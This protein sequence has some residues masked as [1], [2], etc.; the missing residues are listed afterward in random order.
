M[1]KV[2]RKGMNS[3]AHIR[4]TDYKSVR[5]TLPVDEVHQYVIVTD[6]PET[7]VKRVKKESKFSKWKQPVAPPAMPVNGQKLIDFI[8]RVDDE[9]V[10]ARIPPGSRVWINLGANGQWPALVWAIRYCRKD[11]LADILLTYKKGRVLVK[12]YGEHSL[13]WARDQQI[14][15]YEEEDT[16]LKERLEILGKK[17]KQYVL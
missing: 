15:L 1:V 7:P 2:E 8:Q 12:F 5:I 17:Q 9:C 3:I 16:A 4:M 10:K 6:K 14:R 11:D 13:M